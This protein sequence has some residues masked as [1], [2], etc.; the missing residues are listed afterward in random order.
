M[1][2]FERTLAGRVCAVTVPGWMWVFQTKR[3]YLIIGNQH[4]LGYIEYVHFYIYLLGKKF[5]YDHYYFSLDVALKWNILYFVPLIP[6]TTKV[7]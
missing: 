1:L 4:L 3:I 2:T 7:V 5:Y 6:Q